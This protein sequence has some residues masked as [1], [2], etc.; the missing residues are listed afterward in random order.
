LRS[1][2]QVLQVRHLPW[3]RARSTYCRPILMRAR[4][5]CADHVGRPMWWTPLRRCGYSYSMTEKLL[6]RVMRRRTPA[7]TG[8]TRAAGP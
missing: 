3:Q 2:T 6:V 5:R 8:P 1:V 4:Q 7:R